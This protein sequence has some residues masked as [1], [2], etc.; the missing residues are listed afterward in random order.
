MEKEKFYGSENK[1]QPG[2]EYI[3][4]LQED[5]RKIMDKNISFSNEINEIEEERQY[6]LGKLIKVMNFCEEMK[7]NNIDTTTK[8]YLDNIIH[9][10]KHIPED[11][12]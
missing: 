8:D 4:Q 2:N 3:S 11:F 5:L 9:I 6:Y 12:K 10:I 1:P 7:V